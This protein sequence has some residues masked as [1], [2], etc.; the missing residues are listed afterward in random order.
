MSQQKEIPIAI[1]T[2]VA[3]PVP[4]G[5]YVEWPVPSRWRCFNCNDGRQ[6]KHDWCLDCLTQ[7]ITGMGEINGETRL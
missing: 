3:I 7:F 5:D 1:E 4:L 2:T 6:Y